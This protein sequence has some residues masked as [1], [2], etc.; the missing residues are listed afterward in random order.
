MLSVT[1]V[2]R[3]FSGPDVSED[4]D[5]EFLYSDDPRQTSV[6]KRYQVASISQE[7]EIK[8]G[9]TYTFVNTCLLYSQD[10]KH[11]IY[12]SFCYFNIMPL[13][14]PVSNYNCSLNKLNIM[15]EAYKT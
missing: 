9:C 3:L 2:P 8:L 15:M 13:Q 6:K 11:H 14:I 5:T 7:R 12:F 4:L 1:F 10:L